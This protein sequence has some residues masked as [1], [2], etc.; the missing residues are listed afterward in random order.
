MAVRRHQLINDV[1][2][3]EEIIQGDGCLV[4]ESSELWFETLDC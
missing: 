1:I 3:G 2:G 4:V